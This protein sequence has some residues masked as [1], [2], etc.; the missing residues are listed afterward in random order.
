[1]LHQAAVAHVDPA[2]VEWA[3]ELNRRYPPRP[4]S[5]TGTFNILR[6]GQP[7][8]YPE[9]TDAM[10]VAGAIDEEHLRISR[11]L[12][13][14]SALAVPLTARGQTF[15][16]LT[17][18]SAESRR[19]YTND[20]VALASEL[21]RRAALAIDNARQHEAAVAAQQR[22]EAANRAKSD[23]LAAMSHELRT[24]LN[25][26]AG[27]VDLLLAGVRGTLADGQRGDLERV[28]RAQRHLGGLIAE[29]LNFARAEAGRV[30]YRVRPVAVASLLADLR[31][32]VEPQLQKGRL[33][34][35]CASPPVDLVAR[36]DPEKV[37]QVLLNLLSNS[38]KFTPAG[39]RIEVTCARHDRRV[40]IRVHDTGIGIPPD[41]LESVFEPFVQIH[42]SLTESAG[43][44]GLGL[45]ISRDLAR[46]MNGDLTVE[47]TQDGGS[48]FTLSL[49]AA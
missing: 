40:E 23:F 5:S 22:A 27:Y 24:P 37:R 17:L 49:P 36:A 7:E 19:R 34:F 39:G 10:L 31:G 28:Q 2:K 8:L 32:F 25:A 45:A 9:I 11:T 12:G 30:E 6:T 41:R 15:G 48:T 21:A 16:A 26:I 18:V 38:V 43:G 3:R 4:D 1:V 33:T 47:S 14:R 29:V 20:D 42:R 46:G 44:I 13:L 35:D